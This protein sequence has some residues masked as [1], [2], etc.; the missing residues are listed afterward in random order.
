MW[1]RDLSTPPWPK[2]LSTMHCGHLF[3]P[4][5]GF[6]HH[7]LG[8]LLLRTCFAVLPTVRPRH[9]R[10]TAR[11]RAMQPLSFR[12][13]QERQDVAMLRLSAWSLLNRP[14]GRH[15]PHV[16]RRDLPGRARQNFVQGLPRRLLLLE[17]RITQLHSL[18]CGHVLPALCECRRRYRQ[19][20]AVPSWKI[21]QSAPG[22]TVHGLS[23]GH[24]FP[25]RISRMHP[26]RA[27]NSE[28]SDWTTLMHRLRARVHDP[29]QQV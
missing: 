24:V 5:S 19:R 18:R 9:S 7:V 17:S 13:V 16:P 1:R 8:Q 10:G 4:R 23:H 20:A 3:G 12:V 28:P 22:H 14:W 29:A 2:F 21:Q 11:Q 26:M 27:R 25:W 6:V 15:L